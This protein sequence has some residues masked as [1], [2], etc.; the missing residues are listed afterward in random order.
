MHPWLQPRAHDPKGEGRQA[1]WRGWRLQP[2]LY[3][4]AWL[5]TRQLHASKPPKSAFSP[6]RL[7]K[8]RVSWKLAAKHQHQTTGEHGKPRSP[9]TATGGGPGPGLHCLCHRNDYG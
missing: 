5:R 6:A 7:A 1:S 2:G 9:A 4:T 8:V 3:V